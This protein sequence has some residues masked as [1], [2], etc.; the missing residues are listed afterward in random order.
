MKYSKPG[1]VIRISLAR[2]LDLSP[3]GQPGL[4]LSLESLKRAGEQV[5]SSRTRPKRAG[6]AVHSSSCECDSLAGTVENSSLLVVPVREVGASSPRTASS[7]SESFVPTKSSYHHPTAQ[8]STAR[9]GTSRKQA[10]KHPTKNRTSNGSVHQRPPHIL[11]RRHLLLL[12]RSGC[13]G[14]AAVTTSRTLL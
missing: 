1:T 7:A 10:S 2:L 4:G 6:F 13:G 5:C 3:D 11:S 8:H 9:H 12:W 14:G